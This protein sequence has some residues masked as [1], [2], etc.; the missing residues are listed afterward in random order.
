MPLDLQ[1]IPFAQ[2]LRI[3]DELVAYLG[4]A[5][6]IDQGI[7][8]LS[9]L[10]L[11]GANLQVHLALV[12]RF[13]HLFGQDLLHSEATGRVIVVQAQHGAFWRD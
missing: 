1:G 10:G 7:L 5:P 9:L 13:V 6:S 3:L 12:A 8:V 2:H 11:D 4:S